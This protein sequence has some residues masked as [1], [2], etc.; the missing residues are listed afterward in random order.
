M[1]R[2]TIAKTSVNSVD[3]SSFAGSCVDFAARAR[4][5]DSE[6][7]G[8]SSER[9]NHLAGLDNDRLARILRAALDRSRLLRLLC[10]ISASKTVQGLLGCHLGS[11][12]HWESSNDPLTS[13]TVSATLRKMP[14]SN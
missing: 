14:G 9:W 11:G 4:I 1:S 7:D 10:N 2:F 13:R 5:Y 8:V 6:S 3:G 12:S